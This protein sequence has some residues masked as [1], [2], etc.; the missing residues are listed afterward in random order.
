MTKIFFCSALAIVF[1]NAHAESN[2]CKVSDFN[3]DWVGFQANLVTIPPIPPTNPGTNPHTGACKFTISHG[4]ITNGTCE[5]R[6]L[7]NPG[8]PP[9]LAS[10]IGHFD[11]TV[12]V[13]PDCSATLTF[14]F[15]PY[16]RDTQSTYQVQLALDKKTYA[17]R[18]ENTS[19]LL[20]PTNGVKTPNSTRVYHE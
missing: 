7:I 9:V 10:P 12:E 17:G 19:G 6:L 20:G 16:G 5:L 1:L 15:S 14:D 3:G 11:G 13:D 8:P 2:R 18:W 4:T